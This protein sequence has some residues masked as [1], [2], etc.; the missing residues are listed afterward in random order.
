MKENVFD[1]L[2]YLFEHYFN[3]AVEV[4]PDRDELEGELLEAG[5]SRSEIHKAL[6][7][8]DA[9]AEHR[10][11]PAS[12]N[13]WPSIRVYSPVESRRLDTE[14]RGFLFYLEQ[15]GIL[16][17]ANREVV[18]ERLMALGDP[19][20]DLEKLKWVVLMVLFSRP[21][22]EEACAWMESLLFDGPRPLAH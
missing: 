18:I 9:L 16:S 10:E 13:P 3:D 14:C 19:A 2:M 4:D 15:A 22:E 11:L 7:W 5:F 12:T 8:I 1:I 17:P 21:G 6:N 20:V